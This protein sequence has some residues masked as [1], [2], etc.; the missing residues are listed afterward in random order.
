MAK[1]TGGAASSAVLPLL[2]LLSSSSVSLGAIDADFVESIPGFTGDSL[3]S[4]MYS[5]YLPV[6]ETSGAGLGQL[7]Y[8]LIE[9]ESA[10]PSEDPLV[11][12]LNGGPGSSSLIGLLNENGPVKVNGASLDVPAGE[13]PAS[14]YNALAWTQKANVL[15]LEQPKGVGYSFCVDGPENC[16]NTDDNVRRLPLDRDYSTLTHSLNSTQLNSTHSR[17]LMHS[18]PPPPL[19]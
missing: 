13:P 12:W 7:H 1:K 5:G 16:K 18:P 17:S 15:W 10:A 2:L 11:L 3:P 14:F 9:S 6:G 19:F 4:N 8:W